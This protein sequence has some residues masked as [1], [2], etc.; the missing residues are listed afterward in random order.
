MNKKGFTVV[1]LMTT[2]VLV[3]IVAFLLIRL[4]ITLKEIYI[5]GDMKT[6]LLTKQG[7]MTS[8]I[9]KDLEEKNLTAI[10]SCT[11][12]EEVVNNCINFVYSSG[13]KQLKIDKNNK[14]ITYDNYA[15]KLDK[16]GYF[17]NSS[18]DV[19]NSD[20]GNILNLKVPIYN[21][22]IN[23]DFG[24]NIV[25]QLNNEITFDN[26]ITFDD[27]NTGVTVTFDP[28]GGTVTT[29]TKRVTV[30]EKY[31]SL[32]SPK[33]EGYTFKGWA[34]ET[35]SSYN[36]VRVYNNTD[37]RITTDTNYQNTEEKIFEEN[38]VLKFN[39]SFNNNTLNAVEIDDIELD[40]SLFSIT[41]GNVIGK[42]I[43]HEDM[44][45]KVGS[46]YYSFVDFVFANAPSN[47][48]INEFKL[49]KANDTVKSST[50]VTQN[51]NHTLT[52]IWEAN[53]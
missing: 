18:I 21:K 27:T 4:T 51:K 20:N 36:F 53:E 10:T 30:G 15:I 49:Y 9:Y 34:K 28:N 6:F 16:S 2:F 35:Y 33:R 50:N 29:N 45:K 1:E 32:P 7:T 19:Y 46:Y 43:L 38:D 12:N 44:L 40:S 42:I 25:Y 22:L 14:Y 31:G 47:Y 24:I 48:T 5:N 52:A 39:L 8:K 26:N 11:N 23:G 13:T 17:G 3:S 37:L 41:N